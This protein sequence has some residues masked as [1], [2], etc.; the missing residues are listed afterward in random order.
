MPRLIRWTLL[1]CLLLPL[2][3]CR[4]EP[5]VFEYE[6]AAFGT[7]IHVLLVAEGQAAADQA[8]LELNTLF[9]Q[10]HRQWHAWEPGML[11]EIN[12]AIAESRPMSVSPPVQALL[13]QATAL[14]VASGGLFNPAIGKLLALWGFHSSTLP[15]GPPPDPGQIH[16][17]LEEAPS[18][19][20]LQF[21]AGALY[22][23]N[24]AVQIDLG[25]FFKGVA[26]E[27][28]LALL[29]QAGV[30]HALIS[31][32]G[33]VGVIGQRGT[34]PW[35]VAIRHP[36]GRGGRLLAALDLNAGEF[37]FTSGNY[38]RYRESDGVRHGHILDPRS[39]YPA[40][41]VRSVTVLGRQGGPIDAAATALAVADR[42]EWPAIAAAMQVQE[43]LRVNEEGYVELTPGMAARLDWLQE[44]DQI[45]LVV[46]PE[47]KRGN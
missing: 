35:R 45:E 18:M 23:S 42:E 46:L 27:Q 36:D 22:S 6:L 29:Q 34:R 19:T 7:E 25:A 26:V 3:G 40:R 10:Q 47:K 4:Q 24:P 17:L 38:L 5:G 8:A 15:A 31:A 28:G 2:A 37:L 13:E 12:H 21:R 1:L 14:E 16:V 44:P 33:D 30:E 20:Q 32:G 39:G 43:V 9:Q 41:Q 11:V